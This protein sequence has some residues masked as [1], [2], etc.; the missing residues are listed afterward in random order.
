MIAIGGEAFNFDFVID[1]NIHAI[2]WYET[3]G[4]VEYKDGTPNLEIT[5]LAPYQ[6]LLDAHSAE[7]LRVHNE[8]NQASAITEVGFGELRERRDELLSDTDFRMLPDYPGADQPLWVIYRQELRELPD[9]YI[10]VIHPIFP[11]SPL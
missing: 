11:V 4:E 5:S 2:Q 6:S 3:K 1:S 8:D 9:G 10:P 7:S